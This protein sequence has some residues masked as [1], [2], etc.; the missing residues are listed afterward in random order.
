MKN[1]DYISILTV[2]L[3]L[4]IGFFLINQPAKKLE[5]ENENI[6]YVKIAGQRIKVELA[7]T[8]EEQAQGLSGREE[9]K[10]DHGMLFVFGFSGPHLFWMKD[11]NF[12]IDII[13]I[14]E[15]KKV[16]YVKRDA[17]PELYPEMYGSEFSSALYVL[18]VIAGFSEKNNLQIGDEVEFLY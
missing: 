11:M 13:W 9:L 6:E 5:Q 10:P 12:P 17:Q 2:L 7:S 4:V 3:F 16:I 18:E 14:G 1:K 8:P 15:D